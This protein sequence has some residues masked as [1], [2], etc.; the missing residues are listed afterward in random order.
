MLKVFVFLDRVSISIHIYIVYD[1]SV[2]VQVHS[3]QQPYR[4]QPSWLALD[5]KP[6][7]CLYLNYIEI[8]APKRPA[9]TNRHQKRS[10]KCCSKQTI[11]FCYQNAVESKGK[12]QWILGTPSNLYETEL[13]SI[14]S[15]TMENSVLCHPKTSNWSMEL[16]GS[17]HARNFSVLPIPGIKRNISLFQRLT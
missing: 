8:A 12:V 14:L 5:S 17:K 16:F 7:I 13:F 15:S 10:E 4:F 6:C 2:S 9:S 3:F 11:D 1:T